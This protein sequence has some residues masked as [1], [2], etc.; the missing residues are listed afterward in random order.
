MLCITPAVVR[1][2]GPT[3]YPVVFRALVVQLPAAADDSPAEETT[4][5]KEVAV[6][7]VAD[8]RAIADR[9]QRILAATRW[10]EQSEVRVD[11]G[12]VFLT[13]YTES[14]EHKQ[15]AG[16]LAKNTE[17]VVAVVNNIQLMERPLWDL[18]PAWNELRS[19]TRQGFQLLPL[20]G[21]ALLLLL[22]SW[23]L[24]FAASFVMDR[25]LERQM[26]NRLLRGVVVK[27]IMIAVILLGVYLILKVTGLTRLAATVIGGTGLFGLVVGIA[28]RDIAENFLASILI[29]MQRPF[30][31]GDLI[32]VAGHQGIVQGVTTRGTLLMTLDGNHVH[33][34]NSTI[35]KSTI[36][37]LTA[38]PKTRLSFQL[39]I[40]YTDSAAFAQEVIMRVLQHHPAVLTDPE[41]MVL[42]NE[43]A[44]ATVN[45][46]VFFW[47]DIHK[48]SPLK[49]RSAMIRLTKRAC[50]NEGLTLPDEAREVIF[51]RGVPIHMV[52]D[53]DEPSRETKRVA[54]DRSPAVDE[55]DLVS[56]AAEGNLSSETDEIK[57][58]AE[59]SR[60]PDA[61]AEL[62]LGD[63]QV[64]GTPVRKSS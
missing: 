7:S 9:L 33:L 44:A 64:S 58:Q 41:P 46:Q 51:P 24:A 30:E 20:A 48:H 26:R 50:E 62:L 2:A 60:R 38:N 42:V 32:E 54:S 56:T 55:A 14:D 25:L 57:A 45:L 5:A 21:V 15:W 61:G 1:G 40:D 63:P 16:Q 13:G 28:F 52:S 17:D 3:A 23:L 11:E 12:V 29:S 43:L 49:V 6:E 27:T 37:N 8:D 36:K 31:P 10:F 53:D 18:T 39:G 19:M 59:Q 47:I 4:P 34:T 22:A 35:Y